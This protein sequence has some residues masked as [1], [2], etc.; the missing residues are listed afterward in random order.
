VE[1]KFTSPPS[2]YTEANLIKKMEELGIGRPST[3][4]SIMDTLTK[5][6]YTE[7]QGK[8]LVP[9]KLGM[10]LIDMTDSHFSTIINTTYTAEMETK[11][12][13]IAEGK[14]D[15]VEQLKEFYGEFEPLI[16]KAKNEYESKKE[17]P[18][19]TDKV[20]AKC[21]KPLLLRNGKFG[22]FYAC[23]GYPKCKHTEKFVDPNAAPAAPKAPAVD[24]G[25]VCPVCNEGHLVQRTS[26]KGK[27]AGSVFFAC[28]KFPKCKTTFSADK[29]A[30]EFGVV[31]PAPANFTPESTDS[32]L[33]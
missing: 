33:D 26:T 21:G 3:Y 27:S 20:C 32:D 5:R 15:K 8:M 29:F 7:K 19:M 13:E 4:A 1:K 10:N 11:L 2:R 30:A 18:I 25:V 28:N 16:K 31:P 14:L 6:D 17:K 12:D 9:T 22:Q 24:T 23:S